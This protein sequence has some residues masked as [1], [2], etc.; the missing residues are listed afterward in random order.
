MAKVWSGDG[1]REEMW[2]RRW[3]LTAAMTRTSES[4]HCL[5]VAGG[6]EGSW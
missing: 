2:S 1:R 5:H 4:E 3:R 6:D